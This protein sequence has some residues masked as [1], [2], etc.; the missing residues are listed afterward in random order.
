[1]KDFIKDNCIAIAGVVISIISLIR[2]FREGKIYI[3]AVYS[4]YGPENTITIYNN[5]TRKVT[6]TYFEIYH[7]IWKCFFKKES[8]WTWYDEGQTSRYVIA[9]YESYDIIFDE[10]NKYNDSVDRIFN[11][12]GRVYIK[13]VI[14]GQKKKIVRLR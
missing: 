1:M 13:I 12:K 7:S 11:K 14:A 3:D 10:H 2:T 8:A 6:I 9:P 5:S 4:F